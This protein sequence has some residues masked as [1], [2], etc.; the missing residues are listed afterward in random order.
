MTGPPDI[1]QSLWIG[2]PFSLLE[3]L[4]TQSFLNQGHEFHLY[5]Y[6][7]IQGVP[8]G[9]VIKNAAEILPASTIFSYKK[10]LGKGSVSAFSNL[11]RYKLLAE[12]GGW[13]VDSDIVCLRP[14][15]FPEPVVIAGEL[16]LEN[17]IQAASAVLKFPPQHALM[18][19][20][21]EIAAARKPKEL[22]WGDTGPKLLHRLLTETGQTQLIQPPGTFCP[23]HH[24]EWQQLVA[25]PP[26]LLAKTIASGATALHL[27]HERWRREKVQLDHFENAPAPWKRKVRAW[28]KRPLVI[29]EDSPFAMLLKQ[30][31]L[32]E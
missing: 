9:V 16:S 27:W 20:G 1:I 10:G 12:R 8:P 21:H 19:H 6:E 32:R 5:C 23:V 13:W 2:R 7:E 28:F 26:E 11:F 4:C 18:R 29:T 3:K 25:G 17:K 24:W 14:F 15:R 30:H 22:R 31:D